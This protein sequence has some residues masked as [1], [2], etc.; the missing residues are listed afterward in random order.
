MAVTIKDV[1]KRLDLSI[2]TVSRALDGYP[3]I[4]IETRRK[5]DR[6][7]VVL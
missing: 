4:S 5:S 1:A 7:H 6:S 2:A 3:D